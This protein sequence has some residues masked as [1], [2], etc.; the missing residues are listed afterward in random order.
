[1]DAQPMRLAW[2]IL[3]TRI[4]M[5]GLGVALVAC[6]SS[7]TTPAISIGEVT[8]AQPSR[9]SSASGLRELPGIPAGFP[10]MPGMQAEEPL[11]SEPELIGRWTT[12]S[13][14]S[15]VFAFLKDGLPQ[16]G[17]RV[18]LLAPGGTAAIIRFTPPDGEQLQIDLGQEGSGTFMELRLPHD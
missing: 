6:S 17:Y 1:M 12:S 3:R 11:R 10:V 5:A 13:N 16:A 8:T 18:D 7:V 9:S 14:G 4:A 15:A 2:A